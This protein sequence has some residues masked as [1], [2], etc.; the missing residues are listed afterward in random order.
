VFPQIGL[1]RQAAVVI[2][3]L[4]GAMGVQAWLIKGFFDTIP[5]E[6]DESARVDG[7]TPA[8]IFW[9]VV[10]PLAAP[11]LAVVALISFVFTLNEFVITSALLQS[12]SRFTLPVGMNQLVNNQYDQTWG[13]F[14]AGALLAAVPVVIL[15]LFLQRWIIGGLTQGAVKG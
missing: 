14:T 4:G 10:M 6:L 7:A 1:D 2:V 3:F 9:G 11:V 8:Q 15:F 5:V 13:P 12:T